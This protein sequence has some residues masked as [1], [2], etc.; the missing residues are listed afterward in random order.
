M[1]KTFFSGLNA[2]FRVLKISAVWNL[3]RRTGTAW[4]DV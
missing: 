1:K 2:A 3:K 4:K